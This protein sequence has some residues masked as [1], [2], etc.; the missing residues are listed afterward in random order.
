MKPVQIVRMTRV[1]Y[2]IAAASYHS[3]R[4]L[5]EWANQP[6]LSKDVQVTKKR[7]FL[8]DNIMMKTPPVEQAKELKTGWFR[9]LER[10]K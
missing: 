1:T 4:A 6:N 7:D 10:T 9:E 2:S 5:T 8:V 3:I